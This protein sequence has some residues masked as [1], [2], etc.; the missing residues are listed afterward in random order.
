MQL[1]ANVFDIWAFRRAGAQI[2]YLLLHTAQR[3][4]DRW[5]NG[6]RFWQVP[7]NVFGA[8]ER[9]ADAVGRVMHR[10]GATLAGIWA[11]EHAYTIYNR[12]FEAIQLIT[13]FAAEVAGGEIRGLTRVRRARSTCPRAAASRHG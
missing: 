2:E 8:T 9:A 7:S 1:E 12:R 13:V 4:A 5:F 11:A 10:F 6:G 3:K